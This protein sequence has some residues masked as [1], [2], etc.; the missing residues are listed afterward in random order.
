MV[1]DPETWELAKLLLDRRPTNAFEV[2]WK[3]AQEAHQQKDDAA[4]QTWLRIAKTLREITRERT[5]H[6]PLN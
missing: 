4:Y 3:R 5:E 6:D 2:A 1:I